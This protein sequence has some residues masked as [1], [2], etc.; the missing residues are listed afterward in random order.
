MDADPGPGSAKTGIFRVERRGRSDRL[1]GA[2]PLCR[3][4]LHLPG[5]IELLALPADAQPARDA[6][7]QAN[8]QELQGHGEREGHDLDRERLRDA[9]DQNS[10]PHVAL[11]LNV[12]LRPFAN[13]TAVKGEI[14]GSLSLKLAA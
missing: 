3:R 1:A 4:H 13:I 9:G 5:V 14:Q 8:D 12:R 11:R 6:D 2:D 10:E 7:R